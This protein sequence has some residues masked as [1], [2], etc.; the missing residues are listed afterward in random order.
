MFYP[1]HL[2]SGFLVVGEHSRVMCV[3]I[4]Y[5][6]IPWNVL[7]ECC[8]DFVLKSRYSRPSLIRTPWDKH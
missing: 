2:F 7:L 8:M 1:I 6:T 3:M 4:Q 5:R